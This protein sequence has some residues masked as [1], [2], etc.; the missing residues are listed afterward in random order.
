MLPTYIKLSLSVIAQSSS[1]KNVP[2]HPRTNDGRFHSVLILLLFSSS[3]II[4]KF[5]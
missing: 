3:Q 5:N 4:L 1:S 2:A